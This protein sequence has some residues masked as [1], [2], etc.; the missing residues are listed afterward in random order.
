MLSSS[1]SYLS[2]FPESSDLER[3][4]SNVNGTNRKRPTRLFLFFFVPLSFSYRSRKNINKKTSV[5]FAEAGAALEL[6][7]SSSSELDPSSSS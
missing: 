4:W 2:Y 1:S 3:P 6:V 7:S 5:R